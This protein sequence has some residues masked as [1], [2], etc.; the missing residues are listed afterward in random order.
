MDGDEQVEPR[1]MPHTGG[2]VA[3]G[4]LKATQDGLLAA[5]ETVLWTIGPGTQAQIP[6]RHN[7]S[8]HHCGPA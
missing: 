7:A 5:G 8:L 1:D 4:E 3:S 6:A 2:Q